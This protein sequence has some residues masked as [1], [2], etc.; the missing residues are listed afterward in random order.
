MQILNNCEVHVRMWPDIVS[1]VFS[2]YDTLIGMCEVC[3]LCHGL[4]IQ[5]GNAEQ[6]ISLSSQKYT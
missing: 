1:Y 3:V 2:L 6:V 4:K 5:G